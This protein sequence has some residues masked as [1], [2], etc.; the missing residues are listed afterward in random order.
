MGGKQRGGPA[1]PAPKIGRARALEKLSMFKPMVGY[2]VKWI[3]YSSLEVDPEDLVANVRA[4]SAFEFERD[5]AKIETGPD[6]A[7]LE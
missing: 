3:D 2:P 7:G 6:P 4:A 1:L 5:L